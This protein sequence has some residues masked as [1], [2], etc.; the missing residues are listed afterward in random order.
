V[1]A[2]FIEEKPETWM[3][4]SSSGLRMRVYPNP[5]RR[6]LVEFEI[7]KAEDVDLAVH[8]IQG[9][10]VATLV[11]GRREAGS[12]RALW[13]GQAGDGTQ[14]PPGVY[15]CRLRAG[16]ESLSMRSIKPE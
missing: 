16:G 6:P 8:D 4:R 11:R 3:L 7:S 1:L 10:R 2:R 15:V 12:Y 13:N 5:A 9:R 14:T